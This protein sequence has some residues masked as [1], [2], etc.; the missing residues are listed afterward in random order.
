MIRSFSLPPSP[1]HPQVTSSAKRQR[2]PG[3]SKVHQ[4]PDGSFHDL[5]EN[6]AEVLD[7][8]GMEHPPVGTVAQVGT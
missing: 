4:T 5:M 7:M 6:A 8:C 3:S 1:L 2:A